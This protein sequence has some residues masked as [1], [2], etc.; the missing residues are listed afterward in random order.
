MG[1]DE[2]TRTVAAVSQQESTRSVMAIS[3]GD[4]TRTMMAT[5][6]PDDEEQ[7]ESEAQTALQRLQEIRARRATGVVEQLSSGG[8]SSGCPSGS[9]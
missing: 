4:L 1:W 9:S 5:V 2:S 7:A 6:E 3:Q 8:D